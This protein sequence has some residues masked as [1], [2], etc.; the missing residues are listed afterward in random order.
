MLRSF[1][2]FIFIL[3]VRFYQYAIA[4]LFPP[5]CRHQPSCSN[6]MI[7]AIRQ[8]GPWR[9]LKMGGQRL[10]RCHPW[11]GCGSDPVPPV[12]CKNKK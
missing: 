7:E 9:G 3:M 11:G 5:A 4:P 10:C 8:W 6:Y 2:S 12:S 1:F